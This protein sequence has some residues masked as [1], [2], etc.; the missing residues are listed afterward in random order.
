MSFHVHDLN[1]PFAPPCTTVTALEEVAFAHGSFSED[2]VRCL[3]MLRSGHHSACA[4]TAETTPVTTGLLILTSGVAHG[5]NLPNIAQAI[6]PN[7][8]KDEKKP[9]RI[10]REAL[11]KAKDKPGL[12]CPGQLLS[13]TP[14]HHSEVRRP[15]SGKPGGLYRVPGPYGHWL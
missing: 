10:I 3:V 14:R 6:G 15:R 1:V 9:P 13:I 5:N 12:R 8:R 4:A 2:I 7:V 11:A